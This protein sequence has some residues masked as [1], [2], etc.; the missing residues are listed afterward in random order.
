MIFIF[1]GK[2]ENNVTPLQ[3]IAHNNDAA[4]TEL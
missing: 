2:I 1:F 4:E 3:N